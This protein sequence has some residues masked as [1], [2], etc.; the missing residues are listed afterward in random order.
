VYRDDLGEIRKPSCL[1]RGSI[2]HDF[3]HLPRDKQD[4]LERRSGWTTRGSAAGR[5]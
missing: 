1:S 2:A 3:A 5:A 4:G